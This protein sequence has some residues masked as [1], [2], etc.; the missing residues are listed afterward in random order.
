MK[1][2]KIIGLLTLGGVAALAAALVWIMW[3]ISYHG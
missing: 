3:S 2:L 1:A